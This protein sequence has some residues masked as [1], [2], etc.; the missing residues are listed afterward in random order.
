MKFRRMAA[1]IA[2]LAISIS[3]LAFGAGTAMAEEDGTLP[4]LGKTL[5]ITAGSADQIAGHEFTAYQL[6]SYTAVESL[7]TV[8]VK[9]TDAAYENVSAAMTDITKGN[10]EADKY[11]AK[12]GDPLVWALQK[13]GIL[14]SKDTQPWDGTTRK[15]AEQLKP[16]SL[17]DYAAKVTA[18][19]D[20]TSVQLNVAPG[21]YYIVDSTAAAQ[22]TSSKWT[23]SLSMIAST[24]LTVKGDKGDEELS[25]G[26][27][28]LKNQSLPIYKQVV[29]PEGKDYVSQ[30]QPDYAVGDDVYYELTSEVPVFTGYELDSR[31]LKIID[32]MS[33]G[34]TYQGLDRVTVTKDGQTLTLKK[35]IDYT[36]EIS[37]L[38]TYEPSQPTH[39]SG[40]L[41]GRATQ[42]TID[43]GKCVNQEGDAQKLLEG[44]AI[45]VIL[46][47]TLNEEALVSTPGDPQGNPNKVDLKFGNSSTNEIHMIPGGEV[48]VYTFKFQ[49]LKHDQNGKP[50]AGAKFTVKSDKGWLKTAPTGEEGWTT[51]DDE[52]FAKV[53]T[54]DDHGMITGLDGLDAGTYTVKETEAPEGFQDLVLPTFSF[55]ITPKYNQDPATERP[56]S[57]VW[58]DYV[59]TNVDFSDPSGDTWDLVKKDDKVTFQYNVENVPSIIELP[60]TGAAGAI[61]FSAITLFAGCAA[62]LLFVQSRKV[63]SARR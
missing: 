11:T 48:N 12:K 49:L 41:E 43:F 37:Q 16:E 63:R 55:T 40:S 18:G 62:A 29:K 1:G 27:V 38:G 51:T 45:T 26:T 4:T 6:A 33:K 53:F 52:K 47:A 22:L 60:K 58:G 20:A 13:H 44:G 25:D 39:V 34:L 54:S 7:G 19:A 30:E 32:T 35:D 50:L 5:T 31:V 23:R 21:L 2:A 61:M 59:M 15:L 28:Q 46:H 3:G 14:D 9:T 17:G 24:A 36:V 10:A 42:I 56:G 57:A 8:T